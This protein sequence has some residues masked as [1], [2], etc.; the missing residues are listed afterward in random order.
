MSQLFDLA[1][2]STPK[3]NAEKKTVRKKSVK[4]MSEMPT[5]PIPSVSVHNPFA[6]PLSV[7]ALTTRIKENVETSFNNF[8]V[9]GQVSNFTMPRSG[10]AYLTLKDDGAQLPAVIWKST[11]ARLRFEIKNGLELLCTGRLDVYP[12]QGKYQMIVTALEPRGLGELEL[13]FRQL[14]D[15]LSRAGLFDP[16]RKKPLPK[17]IRNVAVI[18]SP[19]GAAVRDFLQVLGRRTKRVNVLIVPAS[20]QGD[21]AA[22]EIATKIKTVHQLAQTRPIDALVITRGGGSR[23]DLWA[24][25]EEILVRAV[26]SSSIPIISA[27]GHEIDVTLCDLA[28]DLRALTPSEAA[29]RI[30]PED[31][32]LSRQLTIIKRR[33]EDSL[34]KRLRYCKERLRLLERQP[35]LQYPERLIEQRRRTIDL[36]EERLDRSLD[37]RVES[38]KERIA[39]LSATVHALSPLAVLAR[40]YGLTKNA[41]GEQVR[42]V[43]QLSVGETIRTRFADGVIVS[44]VTEKVA[45]DVPVADVGNV[46]TSS[47]DHVDFMPFG[48]ITGFT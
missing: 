3:K 36:L 6:E 38:A 2:D 9:I 42:S 27:V 24:F 37:K 45:A 28:A 12:P 34:E 14:H 4:P 11:L 18:T 29:E 43:K 15:K 48:K 1:D 5:E 35:A 7:T 22:E 20:V 31:A 40:G 41:N 25:N 30:A 23:E 13:A 46:D 39:K 17:L 26:A 47:T 21:G 19:S 44:D 33:L 32:E 8:R 16:A 10:H